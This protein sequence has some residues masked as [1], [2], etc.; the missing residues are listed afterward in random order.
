[1]KLQKHEEV[2]EAHSGPMLPSY[3][4]RGNNCLDNSSDVLMAHT[5][6]LGLC[7]TKAK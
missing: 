4:G 2:L 7:S 3:V 5:L 1:M 6:E